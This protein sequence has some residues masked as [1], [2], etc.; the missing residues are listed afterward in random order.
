MSKSF[1]LPHSVTS[2]N[3]E[4]LEPVSQL[5]PAVRD[6][7]TIDRCKLSVNSHV[8]LCMISVCI[9]L[10]FCIIRECSM[11]SYLSLSHTPSLSHIICMLSHIS[12]ADFCLLN[13]IIGFCR[14]L[15]RFGYI[16][17][18]A[19][20]LQYQIWQTPLTVFPVS[21]VCLNI[22]CIIRC[23]HSGSA[24]ISEIAVTLSIVFLSF[25]PLF[26][27]IVLLLYELYSTPV[28]YQKQK[29]QERQQRKS[30]SE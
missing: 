27:F 30:V 22:I 1:D 26:S 18:H 14:R 12:G 13:R 17:V 15:E 29:K 23:I 10:S 7:T 24:M 19:S 6:K 21:C 25:A 20:I 11:N 2:V 8:F 28:R 4:K 9:Y 3:W 16:H 5:P